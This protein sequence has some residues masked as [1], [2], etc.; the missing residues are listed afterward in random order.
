M[1][2]VGKEILVIFKWPYEI[3]ATFIPGTQASLKR[4]LILSSSTENFLTEYLK[5]QKKS[6]KHFYSCHSS[7]AQTLHYHGYILGCALYSQISE[8]I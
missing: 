6:Y 2:E 4:H 7:S 3:S 5:V 1:S 8:N